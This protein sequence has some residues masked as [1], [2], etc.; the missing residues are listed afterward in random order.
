MKKILGL[1][2]GTNSLGWSIIEFNDEEQ[3]QK[4]LDCGVRIFQ[5]V[6][7]DKT[8]VPKN[9]KRREARGHR[10]VKQMKSQRIKRLVRLLQEPRK[11]TEE[12][13]QP[14]RTERTS[15]RTF[16]RTNQKNRQKNQQ[17]IQKKP[18]PFFLKGQYIRY[19][20]QSGDGAFLLF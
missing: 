11:P 5:E 3:P 12:Q 6:T 2:A 13:K 7:E 9:Q 18:F 16:R 17:K 20:F 14:S 10:R 1:D 19:S 15:R 4:I 8:K